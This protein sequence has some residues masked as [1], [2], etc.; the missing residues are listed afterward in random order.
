MNYGCYFKKKKIHSDRVL[1]KLRDLARVV[2]S[3]DRVLRVRGPLLLVQRFTQP[4][5]PSSPRTLHP[6]KAKPYPLNISLFSLPPAPDSLHPAS[7]L[8][9]LTTLGASYKWNQYSV[10]LFETSFFHGASGTQ[11]SSV[12]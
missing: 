10:C 12:L 6:P 2:T 7:W 4:L 11:D 1:G 5:L 9:H 8:M 3:G